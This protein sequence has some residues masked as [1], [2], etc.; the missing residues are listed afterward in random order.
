M[1]GLIA[2]AVKE[3]LV[4]KETGEGLTEALENLEQALKLEEPGWSVADELRRRFRPEKDFK[5][6]TIYD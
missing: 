3:V 4:S 5:E 1:R 6:P 2:Q